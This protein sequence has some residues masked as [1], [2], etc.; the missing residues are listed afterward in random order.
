MVSRKKR[1]NS[2]AVPRGIRKVQVVV[3]E[4]QGNR[5]R[6]ET[7]EFH[8]QLKG[9]RIPVTRKEEWAHVIPHKI[10]LQTSDSK[11]QQCNRSATLKLGKSIFRFMPLSS[12]SLMTLNLALHYF[13][14]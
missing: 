2:R 13:K 14:D 10:Q 11:L 4:A 8:T 9:P 7:K 12:S 3:F 5:L 1:R 6:S